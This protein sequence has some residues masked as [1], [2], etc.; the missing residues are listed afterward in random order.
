MLCSLSHRCLQDLNNLHVS[1]FDKD[2][3]AE[4]VTIS[5]NDVVRRFFNRVNDVVT[6]RPHDDP[7]GVVLHELV[8]AYTSRLYSKDD[9]RRDSDDN[10]PRLQVKA[11]GMRRNVLS[12]PYRSIDIDD[13]RNTLILTGQSMSTRLTLI[14]TIYSYDNLHTL[15]KHQNQKAL[16]TSQLQA[17]A[18][19]V[20]SDILV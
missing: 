14:L 15:N 10:I 9:F 6:H 3:S 17:V 19:S 7:Y 5:S 16:L 18:Q 4:A 1:R 20:D 12:T 11:D 8:V 13:T 2:V